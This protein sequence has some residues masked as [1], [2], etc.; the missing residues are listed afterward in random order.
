MSSEAKPPQDVSAQRETD[1]YDFLAWLEVNKKKVAI[2]ALVLVVIGFAISTMRYLKQQK[3][4]AASGA[5]LALKPVLTPSTNVP[6]AQASALLKVAQDYAGTSAA[7][8]ARILAAT[9]LFTEGRYPDAE[10]EFSQFVKD[11]PESPWVAEAA[12]GVASSQ[13]AQNK[14]SEAQTSYQNVA[15]GYANT[16]LAD[17]AKLALAR[18]YESQKKPDQA[19]RI[20]N[21]LLAPKPGA[22]PGETRNAAALQ[23]KEALL[24]VHPELSTNITA[25]LLPTLAPAIST[26]AASANTNAATPATAATNAPASK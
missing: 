20:Y 10:K 14:I 17:D 2:V 16:S 6:P 24:R 21:E 22:Q 4:E 8:R 12:Y 23:K 11:H 3:E 1:I 5:L 9:A 25:R 13:E 26:N 19:L 7:E 18:I 15:T